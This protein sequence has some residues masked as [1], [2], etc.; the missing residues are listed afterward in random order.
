MG[1]GPWGRR[2]VEPAVEPGSD[3]ALRE[4]Q[5]T[6]E[7][8][9]AVLSYAP[10]RGELECQ[11]CGHVNRIQTV[12]VAIVEQDLEAALRR[13][14]HSAP[15]EDV[16]LVTCSSCNA[17]FTFDANRHA[18]ECPFCGQSIVTDTGVQ[19]Q[20]K[21]QAVLPFEVPEARARERVR[22]WLQGLW[23]APNRLRRMGQV[24]GALHGVYLP[25]WTYDSDTQT[26]YVGRRGEIY[27]EPVQVRTR[28]NGRD[29]V[30]T[31]MV[32]K[33]R[34]YPARGRVRRHFD[35]VL[36]LASKSLP[37]WMTDRL[38][39]WD[40]GGLKPYSA[41]YVTGFQAESY[42]IELG[43]GF[44]VARE[45]M[46]NRIASDVR[47]DIGGDLQQISQ[48]DIRH[49]ETTFKHILLPLWLGAFRYGGK[50]YHVSVNG[51][52]GE[53]QGERPYSMWKILLLVLLIAAIGAAVGYF[54][55]EPMPSTG[56]Y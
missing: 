34:W 33:V 30:Q 19:R 15:L 13:S 21:P 31:K 40:L 36:V 50:S 44:S 52:N 53:V 29:V 11:Y 45:K 16:Q 9:G 14:G 54:Y 39:P 1:I 22:S 55:L 32:Q 27:L 38:E 47:M 23:F 51:Q 2:E 18:G 48:M 41:H 17:S 25:Y 28:V 24:S 12:D 42:R 46:K 7:S 6:C 49:S 56:V 4:A 26:D 20:I 10:G 43:D 8:C 3:H 35:D 5:L 37:T